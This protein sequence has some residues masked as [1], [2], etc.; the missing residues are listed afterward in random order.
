[1]KKRKITTDTVVN[2]TFAAVMIAIAL[3]MARPVFFLSPEKK[4]EKAARGNGAAINL[5]LV[6]Y[7]RKHENNYPEERLVT[8]GAGD[9]LTKEKIISRYPDNPYAK[10]GTRMK[11]VP[12]GKPSPGDFSYRLNKKGLYGI[13]VVVYGRHGIVFSKKTGG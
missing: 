3:L 7:A 6:V 5:A 1:M 2:V 9:I 10:P 12:F 13:E 11:K 8:G 4:V